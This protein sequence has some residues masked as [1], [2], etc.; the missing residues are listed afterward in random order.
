MPR[1]PGKAE[2]KKEKKHKFKLEEKGKDQKVRP[3][4]SFPEPDRDHLH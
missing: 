1:W 3:L 4:A 2:R